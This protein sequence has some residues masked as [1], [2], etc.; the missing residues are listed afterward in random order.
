MGVFEG[1]GKLGFGLM[2]L[3]RLSS[4]EIDVELTKRLVDLFMDAG[5][6]YFDTAWAYE[7]SEKAIKEAL[8]DRYPRERIK[9]ATKVASWMM[10]DGPDDV[11][12]QF[13]ESLADTGA[14]FFDYYLLH[15]IGDSRTAFF[16]KYDTWSMIARK[17]E[18]GLIGHFGVSTHGT[19]EEIDRVLTEH[20]EIEFVQVQINYGDWEN[21]VLQSRKCYET[22]RKH[23]KEITVME[24]IK[25]GM[26]ANPHTKV[27][28]LLKSVR[29]EDSCASWALRFAGSL[30]GVAVVLSGMNGIEQMEDNVRTFK[31]FEPLSES[32]YDVLAEARKIIDSIDLVPCT[33]CKYCEKMCPKDI[34]IP[35]TIAAVNYMKEYE[36]RENGF[37]QLISLVAFPGKALPVECIHCG[38]CEVACPQKL[39]IRECMD[40]AVEE[41]M[42][43]VDEYKRVNLIKGFNPQ[44]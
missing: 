26:L 5:F 37:F 4:G 23:G 33:N 36:S 16:D 18:E 25:G 27:Q 21:P 13:E 41:L 40:I 38:A 14:G 43:H 39:Q 2:R 30:E 6:N 9:F 1:V 7:G 34:G 12:R 19:P 28:S 22:I 8:F 35:G 42:G 44:D 32:E 17:R 3:P 24:P 20:P 11:E 15:N 29:P 31:D 10:C